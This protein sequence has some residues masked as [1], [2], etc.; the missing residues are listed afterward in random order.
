M[1]QVSLLMELIIIQ[2]L[3]YIHFMKQMY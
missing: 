3:I 1:L 2:F